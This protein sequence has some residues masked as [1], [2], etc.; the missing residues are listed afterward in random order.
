MTPKQEKLYEAYM[1]EVAVLWNEAI[2]RC[3]EYWKWMRQDLDPD[4][5]YEIP[6]YKAEIEGI[7][8]CIDISSLVEQIEHYND[9][10]DKWTMEKL[11]EN[12]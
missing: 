11:S 12:L 7:L 10:I 8:D 6:Q 3:H 5:I 1:R 4:D 2:D 9:H